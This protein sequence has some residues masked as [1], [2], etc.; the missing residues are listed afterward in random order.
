MINP[1]YGRPPERDPAKIEMW[2][3]CRD[4]Q[5]AIAMA[6]QLHTEYSEELKD[7][8]KT[9]AVSLIHQSYNNQLPYSFRIT[10]PQGLT[11][12]PIL[13]GREYS[14][15]SENTEVEQLNPETFIATEIREIRPDQI[16]FMDFNTKKW[17][18]VF[19]HEMEIEPVFPDESSDG[20]PEA[21]V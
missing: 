17:L 21:T 5:D 10:L 7:R 20:F 1:E 18:V 3:F 14:H 2:K 6:A 15:I 8:A 4:L 16:E 19:G 13:E 9:A 11:E 12:S